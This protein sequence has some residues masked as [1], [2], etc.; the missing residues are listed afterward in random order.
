MQSTDFI[1]Q[2]VRGYRIESFLAQGGMSW[3]FKAVEE[4]L[5]RVVALKVI[6]PERQNDPKALKRFRYTA[7]LQAKLSHPHVVA[8]HA[9]FQETV[10]GELCEFY[11][12]EFVDGLSLDKI[13]EQKQLT[14]LEIVEI[15]RQVLKA[16][17]CVHAEGIV[18][19]DIKPANILVDRQ[20][21]AKITDFGIATD[22]EQGET[23]MT[24]LTTVGATVGTFAYMAPEQ[25]Q[26]SY[27]IDGR[28]DI[29]AVGVMMYELLSGNHHPFE[30]KITS[31]LVSLLYAHLNESPPSFE[32]WSSEVPPKLEQ[33][34]LKAL[35]KNPNDR[36]AS[37]DE[38]ADQL[39]QLKHEIGSVEGNVPST[40]EISFSA[41][42][43][44]RLQKTRKFSAE[45]D[46][47]ELVPTQ[48][49]KDVVHDELNF[50]GFKLSEPLWKRVAKVGGVVFTFLV[51]I[52]IVYV[53]PFKTIEDYQNEMKII[54]SYRDSLK[55][56]DDYQNETKP[57][58]SYR[59]SLK[60]IGD[61]QTE[62]KTPEH[63][64]TTKD[65]EAVAIEIDIQPTPK[66][67]PPKVQEI[68]QPPPS[69]QPQQPVKPQPPQVEVTIPPPAPPPPA[70]SE[71][72]TTSQQKKRKTIEDYQREAK[73]IEDY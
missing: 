28:A 50:L 33:I 39:E 57:I 7:Q 41:V 15:C 42:G 56:I 36:F 27:R 16:L 73:K 11:V 69:P 47:K 44:T 13:I 49:I 18:H 21:W 31:D 3:V 51:G 61:Y 2:V 59:D 46:S 12:E 8:A 72:D 24:A 26:K 43:Q 4:G 32:E 10:N 38:F 29:Y 65:S 66:T 1:G 63:Y 19:R 20:G 53:D 23:A 35:E 9:F 40:R 34:V 14:Q 60:T 48:K 45:Y 68:I 70:Q 58:G 62:A 71:K 5:N 64:S 22:M 52:Y 67:K 25:I 37:A 54:E 30:K 6:L 55:T 17:A